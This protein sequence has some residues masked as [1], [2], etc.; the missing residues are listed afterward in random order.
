MPNAETTPG[1]LLGR[2]SPDKLSP[3]TARAVL[4]LKAATIFVGSLTAR[5]KK[6]QSFSIDQ[7]RRPRVVVV[8]HGM[9][10]QRLCERI[11][12][13][14]VSQRFEL[15][16]L[17]EEPVPAY[18]RVQ[19]NQAFPDGDV[20]RLQLKDKHW[21]EQHGIRICTGTRVVRLQRHDH[22]VQTEDG[23]FT[24]YDKLI[25][26]T[27]STALRPKE[28][29]E[30]SARTRVLRTHDD[31]LWL[32]DM[33]LQARQESR[34]AV[35]VGGGLLGLEAA[36]LLA[37]NGL[38]VIVI[39]AAP[40][41]LSRQLDPQTAEF[42][43]HLWAREDIELRVGTRVK[44]VADDGSA[45]RLEFDDG[46]EVDAS[47]ALITSGIRPRDDLARNAELRCDLFGGIEINE[48]LE[49]SDPDIYAI[50]ECARF[51]G[52][53]YGLVAPGYDMANVLAER[54]AGRSAAFEGATV[55]TRLKSSRVH[56]S[57][58]G[59]SAISDPLLPPLLL[60]SATTMRRLVLRKGRVVGASILGEWEELPA[61][62]EAVAKG[63]RI[64]SR[65]QQRFLEGES[66]W[67]GQL[68]DIRT[69]PDDAVVCTCTGVTCKT[70]RRA[71]DDGCTTLDALC[72]RT[73]AS[74][75][76][77]TCRPL[78]ATIVGGPTRRPLVRPK[79]L[80]GFGAAALIA[81]FLHL[82]LPPVPLL[83]KLGDG[84]QYDI[85]WRSAVAKQA[86]GFC[87]L[88]LFL[89]TGLGF[90]LRKRW[91]LTSLGCFDK[92]R[93]AHVVLGVSCLVGAFIHTGWRLGHNLDFALMLT[94]LLAS[95]AGAVASLCLGVEARVSPARAVAW[96]RSWTRI[97][98]WLLWPLPVLLLFHV[99]KVYYF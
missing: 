72:T 27:G 34:P 35:V 69:W 43:M 2:P 56:L 7:H 21:Y 89:V 66:V 36:E 46:S 28:F 70:L 76:C 49:T 5:A 26:A 54:L 77:G 53:T 6:R 20:S 87:L 59:E 99:V 90:S 23:R 44:S 61:L 52:F 47:F 3:W 86:S 32:R 75:V 88:A 95:V 51:K 12:E 19:L 18:D 50:G 31:L 80:I 79:P 60:R 38:H 11:V 45:L 29:P 57:L 37:A 30:R 24:P 71:Y 13:L 94:F 4:K 82:L 64:A 97:H 98:L 85:L 8:G 42:F 73:G 40:H 9:V 14:S 22:C 65:Q 81:S 68:V 93:V 74:S 55:A 96:R 33:A 63:A 39:E 84:V 78:I 41:L 25:L 92:W 48:K 1:S 10:A 58:L 15:T 83:T 17:G 91:K 67:P 16:L 62:Q